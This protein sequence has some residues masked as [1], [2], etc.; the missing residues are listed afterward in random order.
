MPLIR[1]A[2]DTLIRFGGAL[3]PWADR[4]EWL[5]EWRAEVDARWG[6][7]SNI[8]RL[9]LV[10]RCLG[11]IPDG[12]AFAWS[13]HSPSLAPEALGDALRDVARSPVRLVSAV[14]AASLLIASS[15]LLL[16][17]AGG[18]LAR[19]GP[20]VPSRLVVLRN[21]WEAGK[22]SGIFP[23]SIAELVALRERATSLR[24]VAAFSWGEVRWAPEPGRRSR[25]ALGASSSADLFEIAGIRLIHG[26]GFLRTD[27]VAGAEPV[28]VL[29][30]SCWREH[31]GADL[32]ALDGPV[33]ILGTTRR[34]V[35]IVEDSRGAVPHVDLW[36]PLSIDPA[37][38]GPPNS[39][40][41][42]LLGTLAPGVDVETARSQIATLLAG[43]PIPGGADPPESFDRVTVETWGAQRGRRDL[44]RVALLALS[45]LGLGLVARCVA[46][47]R[48]EDPRGAR[49]APTLAVLV[50]SVAVAIPFAR[51]ARDHSITWLEV[52]A[53]SGIA[54]ACA[55]VVASTWFLAVAGRVSA[56][57]GPGSARFGAVS[58][59]SAARLLGGTLLLV[60]AATFVRLAWPA[61]RSTGFESEDLLFVNLRLE[62]G[63]SR[64]EL[65]SR[66]VERLAR[67]PVV[68]DV[69][70]G[71]AVPFG[72]IAGSV[73]VREDE[74]IVTSPPEVHSVDLREADYHFVDPGYFETLG[75]QVRGANRPREGEVVINEKLARSLEP[76]GRVLGRRLRI[77]AR[78][79]TFTV[80]GVA[81]D[82][83]LRDPATSATPEV[84]FAFGGT[85]GSSVPVPRRA[86]LL[87]RAKG[88]Q[89]DCRDAVC[90]ALRGFE[91]EVSVA[92]SWSLDQVRRATLAAR[93]RSAPLFAA[94]F[95]LGLSL[96]GLGWTR[97]RRSERA[98]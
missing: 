16:A 11:A 22:G 39:R 21:R 42:R 28:T 5:A 13:R 17:W 43:V 4:D 36:T 33:D 79:R 29:S 63:L 59:Q 9:L 95:G 93:L 57:F 82:L 86:T 37:N 61:F 20:G 85:T 88:A 84:F 70:I 35:G 62:P 3:V 98:R 72:Q 94:T 47:M 45:V 92:G 10:R 40:T 18:E 31:F 65:S 53:P 52:P 97:L 41:L 80:V 67:L 91:P 73:S 8:G 51:L 46:A 96:G 87:I 66:V 58:A 15:S 34:I 27:E 83:M 78:E 69:T 7:A 12:A 60:S 71:T 74:R 54:L 89:P 50:A 14:A 75:I 77:P 30:A 26:R 90:E 44:S 64:P 55:A 81:P 38:P 19:G 32:N 2:C 23:F 68:D 24:S 6:E 49:P 56:R 25:S 48:P 76:S 1:G